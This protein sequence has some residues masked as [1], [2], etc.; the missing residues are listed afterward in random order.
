ML[1]LTLSNLILTLSLSTPV[2]DV[3]LLADS[4]YL[5]EGGSKTNHPYG[6]LKRYKHTSPRQACLNTIFSAQNRF[7]KQSQEKDFILF[8]SKTYCPIGASNDPKG[9]NKNWA[10]NVSKIYSKKLLNKQTKQTN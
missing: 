10:S 3:N 6:I 2:V 4:I 1:F 5:A 8:L 7:A 9:L